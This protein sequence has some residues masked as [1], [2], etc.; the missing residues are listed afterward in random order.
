[1]AKISSR[2]LRVAIT[3]LLAG[4]IA[5][6]AS[7]Q[8]SGTKSLHAFLAAKKGG[9]RTTTFSADVPVIYLVWKGQA[10]DVGDTVGGVW[11]A[12]DVGAGP[13][14]AEIRRADFKVYKPDEMGVFTLSRPTG[15]TWP[16]GKYRVD[17]YINGAIAE[18]AKFTVQPG[19]TIETN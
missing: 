15:K 9:K 2:L 1:M 10:L 14:E 17:L 3:L 13:K 12:E 11:I 16:V 8:S 7:A 18:V 6:A 19:V 5:Q 4:A